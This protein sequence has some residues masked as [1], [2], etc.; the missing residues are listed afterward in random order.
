MGKYEKL[1]FKILRGNSDANIAFSDL[2]NLLKHFGFEMRVR[3]SH[4]LFRKQGVEE[5]I[6]LQQ[7]GNRAK[8][9]QVH[10]VRKVILKNKLGAKG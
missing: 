4:H 3:G 10:Q 7:D 1:I 8:P 5:K 6:N 9:Y 2:I